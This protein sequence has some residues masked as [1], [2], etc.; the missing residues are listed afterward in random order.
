M[1]IFK[2]PTERRTV[3]VNVKLT[4]E[5]VAALDRIAEACGYGARGDVLR[6]GLEALVKH[7]RVAAAAAKEP[8]A[9]TTPADQLN[10]GSEP[11]S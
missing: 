11:N 5:Q 4:A 3:L 1:S 10:E 7:S 8:P 6:A 2:K 9:D